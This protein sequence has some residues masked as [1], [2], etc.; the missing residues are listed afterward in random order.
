[1]KRARV[2][3]VLL[4]AALAS[5]G[6]AQDTMVP[7]DAYSDIPTEPFLL[8][9]DYDTDSL[10]AGATL[11][12]RFATLT[13]AT[14]NTLELPEYTPLGGDYFDVATPFHGDLLPS[15]LDLGGERAC[16]LSLAL[17]W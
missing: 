14:S 4:L 1:M 9:L 11:Q 15:E 2:V 10:T 3:A 5:D 13:L 17:R 8:Q 16:F 12:W 6:A 7:T